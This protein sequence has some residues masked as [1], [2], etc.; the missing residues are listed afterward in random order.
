MLSNRERRERAERI[1]SR[2]RH[3]LLTE[4]LTRSYLS[5]VPTCVALRRVQ[6]TSI[7]DINLNVE[8]FPFLSRLRQHELREITAPTGQKFTSSTS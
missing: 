7:N 3:R 1:N 6:D 2:T 8:K 5:I 4:R